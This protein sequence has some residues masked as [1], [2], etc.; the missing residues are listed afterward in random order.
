MSTKIDYSIATSEQIE[1]ALC[2]QLE[3][4]RLARNITQAQLARESG[5]ALRTI[6]RLEKG[7]GVSLDTFIRILI[8]LRLQHNLKT[9]LP[10]PTVRPIERVHFGGAERKRARP[11]Q[12]N[13]E[14]STWS[15][16]DESV[17]KK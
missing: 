8:A 12:I 17:N 14:N 4:I 6:G 10:D 13:K 1:G 3:N 15:W 2:K 7:K 16:G 11:R 9:L 5:V